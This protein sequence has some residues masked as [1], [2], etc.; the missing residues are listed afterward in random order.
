MCG[1][2][3]G[4]DEVAAAAA[5]ARAR[6]EIDVVQGALRELPS[7][8]RLRRVTSFESQWSVAVESARRAMIGVVER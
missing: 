3:G 4:S 6:R 2:R 1:S 7:V 5:A 8:R